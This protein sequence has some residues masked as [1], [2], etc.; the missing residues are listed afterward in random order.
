MDSR[1]GGG[2][3]G[4]KMNRGFYLAKAKT[5][6][7]RLAKQLANQFNISYPDALRQLQYAL[8]DLEDE[9]DI[10]NNVNEGA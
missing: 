8:M 7:K 3:G 9:T 5:E 2:L 1:R 10:P 4:K 6:A